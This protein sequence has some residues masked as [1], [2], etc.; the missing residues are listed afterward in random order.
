M[1][2]FGEVRQARRALGARLARLRKSAGLTQHALAAKIDGYGRSSVANVETGHQSA[3]RDFWLRCDL[4]L[5][6]NGALI[7][8]YDSLRALM[9]SSYLDS[10]DLI[11]ETA[12]RG[13]AN[14][15]GADHPAPHVELETSQAMVAGG[16][17][18][19]G[20]FDFVV[21]DEVPE[22]ESSPVHD[23][24]WPVDWPSDVGMRGLAGPGGPYS[25][26]A[27]G[28]QVAVMVRHARSLTSTEAVTYFRSG[29]DRAKADD[30]SK[31]AVSALARMLTILGA[32]AQLTRDLEP[33]LRPALLSVGAQGAEFTGWLHRDG[34]DVPAAT[35]W[36]DRAMEWAQEANDDVLQA[37]VLL[38]K[39]QMA[40]DLRNRP[41]AAS[42]AHAAQRY[43]R[44]LPRPVHAEILQQVALGLAVTGAPMRTVEQTMDDAWHLM[45]TSAGSTEGHEGL[46][47]SEDTMLLRRAACYTAA[48]RPASGAE[49]FAEVIRRGGLSRRDSGFFGAR[50]ALALALCGEPD[51]ASQVGIRALNTASET[52]S[53]RTRV[54]LADAVRALAPWRNR[55]GPRALA[56]AMLV[57]PQRATD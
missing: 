18:V 24:G 26:A 16:R 48:G 50:H 3:H 42:L 20:S 35:F 14:G 36:Y 25:S 37:Y 54:V 7:A 12:F 33:A 56:E 9:R 29:I 30:G 53:R 27:V 1:A 55:P 17:R 8:E 19:R 46:I 45:T 5:A 40:Y 10:A 2:D 11:D 31:G 51:E 22:R 6:A 15:G 28:R 21:D 38:R 57:N 39:S 13:S 4:V 43:E 44:R 32:I 34:G 47:I 49:I 41:R 52:D 23:L